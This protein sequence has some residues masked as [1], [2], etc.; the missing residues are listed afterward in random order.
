MVGQISPTNLFLSQSMS[1]F[2]FAFQ[3][4]ISASTA[5][6][7]GPG[8][9]TIMLSA[10]SGLG[11]NM[12]AR[13]RAR[14]TALREAGEVH[15]RSAMDAV[16]RASAAVAGPQ[17]DL[18]N[19]QNDLS[20]MQRELGGMCGMLSA[21]QVSAG[22]RIRVQNKFKTIERIL[23]MSKHLE[24]KVRVGLILDFLDKGDPSCS[25][26]EAPHDQT[27]ESFDDQ[28][29]AAGTVQNGTPKRRLLSA[30]K[31]TTQLSREL[32]DHANHHAAEAE[33]HD[34]RENQFTRE[35]DELDADMLRDSKEPLDVEGAMANE[36]IKAKE[37]TNT[38]GGTTATEISEFDDTES[39]YARG[40]GKALKLSSTL[41]DDEGVNAKAVDDVQTGAQTRSSRRRRWHFHHSN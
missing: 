40:H 11:A 4:S 27:G 19:R 20:R 23:D 14:L 38:Q 6:A 8:S 41:P 17:R 25:K 33:N 29:V 7:S 10:G 2:G 9:F 35:L 15:I 3:A 32:D 30:A 5:S 21:L 37:G 39:K 28:P 13:A 26:F 16:D 36:G 31:D 18:Q 34:F 24:P 1:F 12:V 22:E